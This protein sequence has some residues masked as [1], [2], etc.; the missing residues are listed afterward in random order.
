METTEPKREEQIETPPISA[1]EDVTGLPL[2]NI[3]DPEAVFRLAYLDEKL[4]RIKVE[5]QAKLTQLDIR[6][7]QLQEERKTVVRQLGMEESET[8]EEMVRTRA[9]ISKKYG[10]DLSLYGYDDATGVLKLITAQ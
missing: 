8:T 4:K 2:E 9:N 3:V 7:L 6:T 1:E 10:I 5:R